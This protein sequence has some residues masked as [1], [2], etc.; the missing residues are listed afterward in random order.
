MAYYF[1]LVKLF[2]CFVR[3]FGFFVLFVVALWCMLFVY[4]F[5]SGNYLIAVCVLCFVLYTRLRVLGLY[6]LR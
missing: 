2:V 1:D 3:C 5:L 6:L 4:C